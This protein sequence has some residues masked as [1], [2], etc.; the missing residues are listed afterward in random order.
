MNPGYHTSQLS[1][2]MP[3]SDQLASTSQSPHG[4]VFWTTSG[5]GFVSISP[6]SESTVIVSNLLEFEPVRNSGE[7]LLRESVRGI[8]CHSLI[9]L[10]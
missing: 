7:H 3:P 6:A 9:P 8:S 10:L 5:P 1:Q 4:K 2:A